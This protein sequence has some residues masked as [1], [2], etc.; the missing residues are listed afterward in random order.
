M[1]RLVEGEEDREEREKKGKKGEEGGKEREE[2]NM[3][4]RKGGNE[5]GRVRQNCKRQGSLQFATSSSSSLLYS[6]SLFLPIYPFS[7]SLLSSLPPFLS[8]SPVV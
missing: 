4:G 5:G 1:R 6:F 7:L 8:L 3:G 2:E